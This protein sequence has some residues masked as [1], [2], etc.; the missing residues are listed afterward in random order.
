MSDF[1]DWKADAMMTE[2]SGEREEMKY[3]SMYVNKSRLT[4]PIV[5]RLDALA[6]DL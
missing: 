4:M 6:E 5:I 3:M 2:Q 1:F